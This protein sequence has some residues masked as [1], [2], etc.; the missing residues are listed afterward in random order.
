[1]RLVIPF[2]IRL[3]PSFKMT[4]SASK[5]CSRKDFKSLEIGPLY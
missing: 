3:D 1:M 2:D 4:A 5:L